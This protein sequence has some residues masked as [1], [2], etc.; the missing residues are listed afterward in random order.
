M[1]YQRLDFTRKCAFS[2]PN[3]AYPTAY[4]RRV[5]IKRLLDDLGVTADK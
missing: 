1:T 2:I 5:R 4:I 3:T